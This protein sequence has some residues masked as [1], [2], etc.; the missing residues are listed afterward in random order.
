[1][2]VIKKAD[3]GGRD[4][5]KEIIKA[6]KKGSLV[7]KS[8]N[9]IVGDPDHGKVKTLSIYYE[10][11]GVENVSKTKEGNYA[12][13]KS[14]NHR[15]LGIFYSNNNRKSIYKAIDKSLDTI[16]IASDGVADIVTCVW[17]PIENN[18]FTEI[19]AWMQNAGHLNQLTQ[20]MQCLY[21]AKKTGDYEYVSFLEH[22]VMY[23]EDYFNY[24]DFDGGVLTNMNYIG[25]CKDGFQRKIQ[26]DEPFHQM[27][28]RF[29]DAIKHCES[30]MENALLSNSGYIE[31]QLGTKR[32]Q[33][34]CKTPSVHINHG[35][36][37]T[38]H[39]SIYDSIN[40]EKENYYW[41][42]YSKYLDL[43]V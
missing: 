10:L 33:W 24:K 40:T 30:I 42:H 6:C 26:N 36:H 38:S 14:S 15:K 35:V 20:I 34:N 41:G 29:E 19:K 23:G 8:N 27:T 1:M 18:P 25:I 4:C 12:I 22:D 43:F 13:I 3:Y 9:D 37:F 28:M 2:L 16:K 31:P 5:T 32:L 11:N 17:N 21:F 7:I 39:F